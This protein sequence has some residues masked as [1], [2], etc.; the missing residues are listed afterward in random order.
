MR[1]ATAVAAAARLAPTILLAL[2]FLSALA[3]L[4]GLSPAAG[5]DDVAKPPIELARLFPKE[6]EVTAQ[7]GGL[8]RLVL[9]PEVLA[10][11]RPDLSDLR[12]F[13]AAGRE[14]SFLID[15]GGAPDER[16]E[17]QR[18]FTPR[19][20]DS[21]RDETPRPGAP[22]LRRETFDLSTPGEASPSAAAAPGGWTLVADVRA[23]E[24]VARVR[25][26]QVGAG[27]TVMVLVPETSL[28]RLAGA[29]PAE[30]T[31]LPL[32]PLAGVS[33]LRVVL[34]SEQ[35][36]WLTPSFTLESTR[37]L[38]RG[39][40]IAVPLAVVVTRGAEGRTVAE[41]ERPRGILP[42]RLH[43]ETSTGTFDRK[44]EIRDV[45]PTGLGQVI[46][47]G[48]VFRVAAL[49]PVGEQE[50]PVR[51][52]PRGEKLR[53]EIE[54]GDSPPLADLALSAVVRQPSLIFTLPA[55]AAGG[56]A[57]VLRFGGGRAHPARYD[58]SGLLPPPGSTAT[59]RRAE[60]AA[61]LY[62]PAVV[63]PARLGELRPNPGYDRS[64]ALA[65]AMHPGAVLDA[66]AFS[67]MRRLVVP[68][69]PEGLSRLRLAPEDLAVL[70]DDLSDLRVA[71]AS[72]QQW[73]YLVDRGAKTD[74]VPLQVTGPRQEREG[75]S[76]Y[77]IVPK[78][79][80]LRVERLVL[81]A[82]GG[83][84]DR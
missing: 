84:F 55:G 82:D 33:R 13:D 11:C 48:S 35:S 9:P 59:G 22:S 26:E 51:A 2:P 45:G 23:G 7:P 81:E 68:D 44:V 10:E 83:F 65:F 58:L 52:A 24:F 57:G 79:S 69:A 34:E 28:F 75:R 74:L 8:S 64:P 78:T 76:A 18:R 6:A 21:R 3:F 27:G 41:A 25:V 38:D 1:A 56:A 71:D 17:A 46:G 36:T 43:V 60:A 70:R 54:D 30:K 50:V 39:G 67:H 37:V 12:L 62:D 4:P 20:L 5:A 40:Q 47:S 77:D 15:S 73:P 63:R 19:L 80:P 32:P 53:I 61:L 14:T 49:V 66:A 42:D 29:R 31:R 72:S 16:I